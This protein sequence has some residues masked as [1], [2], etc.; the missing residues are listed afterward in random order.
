LDNAIKFTPAGGEI[1][2]TLLEENR[3]LTLLIQDTGMGIAL[4]EQVKIFDRF[5]RVASDAQTKGTG[6]GLFIAKGLVEM[7]NG[8]IAITSTV[9]KGSLFSITLPTDGEEN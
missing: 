4:E 1:T 8:K 3:T 7:H 2:L 5:Y 6:L 9:G